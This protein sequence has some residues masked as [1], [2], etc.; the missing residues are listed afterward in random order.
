MSRLRSFVGIFLELLL[1][2]VLCQLPQ[3]H[4][5]IIERAPA[6][7]VFDGDVSE[8]KARSGP[9]DLGTSSGSIWVAQNEHGLI[10][11]MSSD[12][13]RALLAGNIQELTTK[14]RV[15]M[16]LREADRIEMPPIA[17]VDLGDRSS[18]DAKDC[19]SFSPNEDAQKS[20]CLKWL[21]DQPGYRDKLRG[22]FTRLWRIAPDVVD[23]G[24]ATPIY[25]SL[26]KSQAAAL[27]LLK[28]AGQPTSRFT[29]DEEGRK[30]N[31]EILIPWEAFPPA[32]HLHMERIK[33]AARLA[34]DTKVITSTQPEVDEPVTDSNLRSFGLSPA[35][36]AHF[37]PCKYPLMDT[38]GRQASYFMT[39]A[40]DVRTAFTLENTPLSTSMIPLVEP[41]DVSARAYENTRFVQQL[42]RGE[43]LCSPPLSYRKGNSIKKFPFELG[44]GP[45]FYSLSALPKSFPVIR[46]P[47]GTRL[48]KEGPEWLLQHQT[49][50]MCSACPLA[51]LAIYALSPAGEIKRALYIGARVS[52]FDKEP[53]DYDIQVSAD[54]R[55]V[56]EFS[57]VQSVWTSKTYCLRGDTYQ[58]CGNGTQAPPA[59]RGMPPPPE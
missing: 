14:G 43:F 26:T 44:P 30:L 53:D 17:W 34:Y 13:P 38:N 45:D 25:A 3:V 11:A 7:F 29:F 21:A 15:E 22:L 36:E 2:T 10:I 51:K 35:V 31:V 5:Q 56:K 55:T 4:A 48:I 46:L 12:F 8:W 50:V 47:N 40:R 19:E 37:T 39:N 57:S 24:N 23:E 52:G 54:W 27:K 6:N 41:D 59:K 49:Y 42:S 1:A 28:P 18:F 16:W 33:L 20:V 9:V 58:L 32:T